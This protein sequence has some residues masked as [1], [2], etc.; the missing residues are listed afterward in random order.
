MR[1]KLAVALTMVGLFMSAAVAHFDAALP[2]ARSQCST[3]GISLHRIRGRVSVWTCPEEPIG[4][5][6]GRRDNDH[7]RQTQSSGRR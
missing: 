5:T 7:R 1:T 4:E 2:P 3:H 6:L